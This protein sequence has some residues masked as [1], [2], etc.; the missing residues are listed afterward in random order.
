[1][2]F[3][4]QVLSWHGIKI[5]LVWLLFLKTSVLI[6]KRGISTSDLIMMCFTKYV[7]LGFGFGS[8]FYFSGPLWEWGH[9]TKSSLSFLPS[10][11]LSISL[12]LWIGS[13]MI[14][15]FWSL[16]MRLNS[17]T[18]VPKGE[19]WVLWIYGIHSYTSMQTTLTFWSEKHNRKKW[20]FNLWIL[21]EFASQ[22]AGSCARRLKK[23]FQKNRLFWMHVF[24]CNKYE[25]KMEGQ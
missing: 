3:R 22:R 21:R 18:M 17:G 12:I 8:P 24:L 11:L 2:I 20:D 13:S 16:Y 6:I 15:V 9:W 23:H 7:G 1:M 25:F 10:V 14:L 19:I 5:A 4:P